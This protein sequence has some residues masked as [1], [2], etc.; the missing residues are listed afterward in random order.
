MFVCLCISVCKHTDIPTVV[1][2]RVCFHV[3]ARSFMNLNVKELA[4]RLSGPIRYTQ[5]SMWK[6]I[7]L[8]SH[9]HVNVNLIFST[10]AYTSTHWLGAMWPG[11]EKYVYIPKIRHG[12]NRMSLHCKH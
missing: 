6:S 1:Q 5:R 12:L 2:P 3:T 9:V 7:S 8:S 10:L 11:Q 4:G